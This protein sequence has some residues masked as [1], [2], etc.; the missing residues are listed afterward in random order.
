M[1]ALVPPPDA[2]VVDDFSSSLYPVASFILRRNSTNKPPIDDPA[3]Q[4]HANHGA[5]AATTSHAP[6]AAASPQQP[7]PHRTP[8]N[9][10]W[11]TIAR[12]NHPNPQHV[13]YSEGRGPSSKRRYRKRT[14]QRRLLTS[15]NILTLPLYL[16]LSLSPPPLLQEHTNQ[17]TRTNN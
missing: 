4:N 6:P 13:P 12:K 9:T 16:S 14:T 2:I 1:P 5:S 10:T 7:K 8:N 15:T 11:A 17:E 3:P